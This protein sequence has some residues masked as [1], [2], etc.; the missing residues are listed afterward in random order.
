M[1]QR[2][3]RFQPT[4]LKLQNPGVMKRRPLILMSMTCIGLLLT[5]CIDETAGAASSE[6]IMRMIQDQVAKEAELKAQ[7]A[8]AQTQLQQTEIQLK[9]EQENKERAQRG[10][11]LWRSGSALLIVL[12]GVMLFLGAAAGSATRKEALP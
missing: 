5:S 11:D 4:K 12:A 3:A 1:A 7:Q 10:A 9:K 2:I 6:Q 8:V